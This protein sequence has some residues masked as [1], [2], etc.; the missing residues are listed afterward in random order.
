ML[1]KGNGMR[2][3]GRLVLSAG[4][5]RSLICVVL[6][7]ISVGAVSSGLVPLGPRFIAAVETAKL[8][9][10]VRE[11]SAEDRNVAR[12]VA[13]K[14]RKDHLTN[15][16]LDDEISRRALDLFLK[17]LDGMKLY[18]YQADVDEFH[19]RRNDLDEMINQGDVS[20]AYT[21]FNRLLKRLDE[22]LATVNQLLAG[23]FDFE[24]D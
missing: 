1:Q 14:T 20:F 22:R 15:H 2:R 7:A 12:V 23:Q 10:E 11:P 13:I 17:S 6:V 5:P 4:H 9:T 19:Q 24:A 18:F 21:V 8:V 3:L 16:P